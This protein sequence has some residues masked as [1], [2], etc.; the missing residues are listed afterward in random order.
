MNTTS[1]LNL[2]STRQAWLNPGATPER[3]CGWNDGRRQGRSTR[4]RHPGV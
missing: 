1:R 3:G 4:R 2:T